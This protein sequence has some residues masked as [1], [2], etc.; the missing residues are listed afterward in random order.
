MSPNLGGYRVRVSESGSDIMFNMVASS[1][2]PSGGLLV[3]SCFVLGT[4]CMQPRTGVDA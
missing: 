1:V 3:I 2:D 4:V